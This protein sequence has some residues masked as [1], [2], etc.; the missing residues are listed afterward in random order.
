LLIVEDPSNLL[1]LVSKGC[2]GSEVLSERRLGSA[3]TDGE[4]AGM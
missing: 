1:I 4:W 2:A 3:I